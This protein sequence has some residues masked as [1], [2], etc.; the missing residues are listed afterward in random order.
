MTNATAIKSLIKQ[1]TQVMDIFSA[2][3]LIKAWEQTT[4]KDIAQAAYSTARIGANYAAAVLD[5]NTAL[6]LIKDLG[7]DGKV[8]L[9]SVNGTQYVIFK[10]YAGTR[11]I[12]T[13]TR[14]L[15]NNPKV[16]DMAIGKIGANRAIM[17]GARLTIFLVVPLN[18]LN[19]ILSDQQT[20]SQMIGTTATDLV[21]VGAASAIASIAATAAATLTTLAAGPIVVAIVVGVATALAL[22]ALDKQFGVTDALIKALD[23][24]YDNTV[25]EFGRQL[26]QVERRLKWQIMNGRP[27]GQG[28]FY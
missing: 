5:A 19:Y 15:A 1:N 6:K 28:I 27:V 3:D 23:D 26:N 12:F 21:K 22:D 11:S 4:G 2:E 25:G 17:S 9:K 20:M 8:V 18:V 14:Y 10:G 7:I 24:A 16:V 13:A